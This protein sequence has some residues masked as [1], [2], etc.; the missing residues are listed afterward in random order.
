[1]LYCDKKNKHA[2]SYHIQMSYLQ[3]GAAV[4][5]IPM[6]AFRGKR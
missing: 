4:K 1:M 5:T 2:W 6:I 3:I